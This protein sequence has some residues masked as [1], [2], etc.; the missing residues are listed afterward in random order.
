MSDPSPSS[1]SESDIYGPVDLPPGR[2]DDGVAAPGFDEPCACAEETDRDDEAVPGVADLDET[3]G[4]A[5]AAAFGVG[6]VDLD[7]TFDTEVL[8]TFGVAADLEFAEGGDGLY[9]VVDTDVPPPG[10]EPG[11]LA[12]ALASSAAFLG[13]ACGK[14]SPWQSPGHL[15]METGTLCFMLCR[16]HV[17]VWQ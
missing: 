13:A 16:A 1:S 4:V 9:D 11:V 14:R 15:A 10:L 2:D 5:F 12:S 7:V 17:G 8:E 6:V 3:F